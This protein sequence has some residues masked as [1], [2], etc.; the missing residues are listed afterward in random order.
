MKA[1]AAMALALTTGVVAGIPALAQA[2]STAKTPVKITATATDF[3]F[4]MSRT[5]V[6]AGTPIVLTLVN[7]GPSPHDWAI[8][9]V[10]KTRVLAPSQRQT[11]RFTLSKKGTFRFLCTVPR[12]AQFGMVGNLVVR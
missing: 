6:P 9:G 10:K 3:D 12:H 2:G 1:H 5:K 4:K 11:I 7:K 8:T